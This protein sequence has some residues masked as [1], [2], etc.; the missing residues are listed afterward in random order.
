MLKQYNSL[1]SSSSDNLITEHFEYSND[2]SDNVNWGST[3]VTMFTTA[4]TLASAQYP[5]DTINES[6]FSFI[7]GGIGT[8]LL[9]ETFL[10]VI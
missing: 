8:L 10:K 2:L 3:T 4:S 6:Q 7:G 1:G 9:Q 5:N